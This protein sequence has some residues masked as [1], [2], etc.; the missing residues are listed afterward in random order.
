MDASEVAE[1]LMD[2]LRAAGEGISEGAQ[3]A[4]E[5]FVM[6]AALRG[7]VQVL[8]G[9]LL[10]AAGVAVWKL[11]NPS[12]LEAQSDSFSNTVE[13][14]LERRNES[15]EE[16]KEAFERIPEEGVLSDV[17]REHLTTELFE[18][19]FDTQRI[20]SEMKSTNRDFIRTTGWIFA[21]FLA[22]IPW[23][24]ATFLL[25]YGGVRLINPEYFAIQE[26]LNLIR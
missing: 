12:R 13:R 7:G 11:L 9:L 5:A 26:L 4:F 20:V 1:E 16:A 10:V 14:L 2:M 15:L 21:R 3:F 8:I 23:F 18:A 22:F 17:M 24:I 19:K 6:Q 25:A